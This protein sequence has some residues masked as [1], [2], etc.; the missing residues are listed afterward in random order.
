MMALAAAATICKYSAKKA[1]YCHCCE[2]I[3]HLLA[4]CPSSANADTSDRR[5]IIATAATVWD[6]DDSEGYDVAA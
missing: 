4:Q 1:G 6:D 3:G 5:Q 2:G